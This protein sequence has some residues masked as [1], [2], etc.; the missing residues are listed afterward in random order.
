MLFDEPKSTIDLE[1][2]EKVLEVMKDL[3]KECMMM[4]VVTHEMKFG[5]EV[6]N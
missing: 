4:V 5:H 1:L 6:C 3:A 2:V